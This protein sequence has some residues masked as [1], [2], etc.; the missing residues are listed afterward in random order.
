MKKK[1]LKSNLDEIYPILIGAWR[2]F[3]KESGPSEKLQ[4][5]EFRRVVQSTKTLKEIFD[6]QAFDPNTH[7][8]ENSQLLSDYLLYF[9]PLYYQEA[10]S[11]IG[12]IPTTPKRVLDIGAG[13]APFSFAALRHGATEVF[14]TDQF[15]PPLQL[16]AEICGKYGLPLTIRKWD[17]HTPCPIEGTFDL[18]ILGHSLQEI[19]ARNQKGWRERQNAFIQDLLH[20]K[21]SKNGYLLI[22]DSSLNETNQSIL[23]IRDHFVSQGVPVQAPCVWKGECPALKTQNSPCYAQREMEKPYL[24]KEIQRGMDYHLNSLKMSY[25]IFKN[26]QSS[27]PNNGEIPLYRIISPPVE[28]FNTN[29]YY[30]CGTDGKKTLS[31]R[32]EQTPKQAKAFDYLKRGELIEVSQALNRQ[33]ALDITEETEIKVVAAIGKPLA[34]ED[35]NE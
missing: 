30:L 29:K 24:L 12:E 8:F 20:N 25:I 27:W 15:M 34:I 10:L 22:V 4:T 35:I 9:W 28:A 31:N 7:Y 3:N 1:N 18:I 19:F 26:P 11:V 6:K 33:N 23:Q 14:A 16:G 2:R 13:L 32:L 17:C 21:L 5:R